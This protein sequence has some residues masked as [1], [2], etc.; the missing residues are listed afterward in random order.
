MK[1]F[2][3]ILTSRENWEAPIIDKIQARFEDE[4]FLIFV[5]KNEYTLDEVTEMEESGEVAVSI[6]EI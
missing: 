2:L 4:A 6:R 1:T 5:E 3:I